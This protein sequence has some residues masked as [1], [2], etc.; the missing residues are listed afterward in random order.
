[1][2]TEIRSPPV[3]G[4]WLEGFS[5]MGIAQTYADPE[6]FSKA[7]LRTGL[8]RTGQ[9]NEYLNRISTGLSTTPMICR[10]FTLSSCVCTIFS[11]VRTIWNISARN[12]D[13]SPQPRARHLGEMVGLFFA[14]LASAR[15]WA[16]LFCR[17]SVSFV[18]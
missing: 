16:N 9:F 11:C 5:Q 4:D 14:D 8:S 7:K 13:L 1:M 17:R 2:S 18:L 3:P 12:F 6:H 10:V 15:I